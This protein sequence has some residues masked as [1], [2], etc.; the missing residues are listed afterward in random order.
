MHKNAQER[1]DLQKQLTSSFENKADPNDPAQWV[2]GQVQELKLKDMARDFVDRHP[3][4]KESLTDFSGYLKSNPD[5][6]T[7]T[8]AGVLTLDQTYAMFSSSPAQADKLREQGGQA[9]LKKLANKQRATA[10]TGN[11]STQGPKTSG[12]SLAELEARLANTKF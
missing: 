10:V 11:A 6:Q 7:L 3:D 2:Q 8:E 9:A 4:A 1:A 5:L 12:N